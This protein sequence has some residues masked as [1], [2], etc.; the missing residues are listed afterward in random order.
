MTQCVE[1]CMPGRLANVVWAHPGTGA[2]NM[3]RHVVT[4]LLPTSL[5]AAPSLTLHHVLGVDEAEAIHPFLHTQKQASACHTIHQ[6]VH[7]IGMWP[8]SMPG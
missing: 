4:P 2:P 7:R 1:R 8:D 5:V 6:H 3:E